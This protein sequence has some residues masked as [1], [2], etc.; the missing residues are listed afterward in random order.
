MSGN[1]PNLFD[2]KCISSNVNI[3]ISLGL[4]ESE[5]LFCDTCLMCN[6]PHWNKQTNETR[7]KLP[8]KTDYSEEQG[9]GYYLSSYRGGNRLDV[10]V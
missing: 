1:R 8:R 9:L 5:K 10:I 3:T 4:L 2:G 7:V 6:K